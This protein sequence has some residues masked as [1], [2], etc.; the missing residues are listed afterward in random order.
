VMRSMLT[1]LFASLGTPMLVA[2]DEFGRTQNGN[3]NAYC[4]DNEIS[5][6]DWNKAKSPEGDALIDFT[7]RLIALRR[8]YPMLRAGNFL[9]GEDTPAEGLKDIEWWD[10]R[11]QQLTSADWENTNGRA[12]VMRRACERESGEVQVI[13]LLLNASEG[14]L[15][16]HMPPPEEVERTVLIDSSK[17]EQGATPIKNSYELPPQGAALLSWTIEAA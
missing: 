1:T 6:L 3:N 4:Q 12:L 5:W 17:P 7:A 13:S 9:Y 16:F 15:T 2:G 14:P 10:E 11:G 8:D